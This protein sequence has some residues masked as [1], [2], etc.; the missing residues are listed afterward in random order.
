[1]CKRWLN[2]R[3]GLLYQIDLGNWILFDRHTP[4]VLGEVHWH[5]VL[6]LGRPAGCPPRRAR[7]TAQ[8]AVGGER[9][10]WSHNRVQSSFV[11]TAQRQRSVIDTPYNGLC[12]AAKPRTSQ[13]CVPRQVSDT[14]VMPRPVERRRAGSLEHGLI[15][16]H[17]AIQESTCGNGLARGRCGAT[18]AHWVCTRKPVVESRFQ[19]TPRPVVQRLA[20]LR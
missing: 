8:A 12:A 5:S 7:Q 15:I 4:G 9:V 10:R 18:L 14:H 6:G 17:P 2:D 16:V 13:V 3:Y 1:V 20:D 11:L 19:Y